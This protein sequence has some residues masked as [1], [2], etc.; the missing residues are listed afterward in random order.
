MYFEN[1]SDILMF[2]G[3]VGRYVIQLRYNSKFETV[4]GLGEGSFAEVFLAKKKK[5]EEGEYA[6]KVVSKV[7][8]GNNSTKELVAQEKK[9]LEMV[10]SE[11]LCKMVEFYEDSTNYY[12]VL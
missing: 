7:D 1:T 4:R 9:V 6:V 2:K 3:L 8:K 5:G 12:F 10:C 11:L